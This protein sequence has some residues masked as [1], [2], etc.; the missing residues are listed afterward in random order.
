V[1]AGGFLRHEV[2]GNLGQMGAEANATGGTLGGW[3]IYG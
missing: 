1:G 2:E 3:G